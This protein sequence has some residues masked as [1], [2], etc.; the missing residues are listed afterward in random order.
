MRCSKLRSLLYIVLIFS[1]VVSFPLKVSAQ[2]GE[3]RKAIDMMI[4]IDNSCSMFPASQILPG[5]DLYGSDPNFLRI[6]GADLFI[7]RLGF[8]EPN[9]TEYQVGVISVGDQPDLITPLQPISGIRDQV[10]REIAN[11]QPQLATRMVP[12]LQMAYDEFR[13]SPNRRLSNLPAIVLIT[14]GVPWPTE[15]QGLTQ[16]EDLISKNADTPLFVLLLQNQGQK[17]ASKSPGPARIRNP[18]WKC[19]IR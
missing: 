17:G 2:T 10:A 7:A 15:G 12:A 8:A 13:N 19:I 9:E 11:P 1:L 14:D 5:C 3:I 6:V 4:L 18:P 16:I